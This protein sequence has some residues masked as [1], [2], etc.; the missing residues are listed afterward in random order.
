MPQLEAA[1]LDVLRRM[2][3]DEAK[4]YRE[5]GEA[6][7]ITERAAHR[8]LTIPNYEVA[9]LTLIKIR[10]AREQL[11]GASAGQTKRRKTA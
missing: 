7:G 11:H 10:K 6:V 1:E 9:D 4:T 2:R 5:I 8:I 3:N